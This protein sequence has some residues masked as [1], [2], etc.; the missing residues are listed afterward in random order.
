MYDILVLIYDHVVAT[1]VLLIFF[2]WAVGG[3]I[4]T[5]RRK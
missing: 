5:I 1:C 2:A 4:E 3:I